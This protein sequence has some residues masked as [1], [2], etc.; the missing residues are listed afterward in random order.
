MGEL[1]HGRRERGV[2]RPA[3]R[4]RGPQTAV[5]AGR[6]PEGD[7]WE[8]TVIEFVEMAPL[9]GRSDAGFADAVSDDGLVRRRKTDPN[10][11]F[12]RRVGFRASE[13]QILVAV[14]EQPLAPRAN[15]TMG[16][17]GPYGPATTTTYRPHGPVGR[18]LGKVAIDLHVRAEASAGA[19]ATTG[20]TEKPS[21][22][23]ERALSQLAFLPEPVR[24]SVMGR[25]PAPEHFIAEAVRLNRGSIT[26]THRVSALRL[27][28]REA[29]V[30]VGSL[31]HGATHWQVEQRTY[32]FAEQPALDAPA[33]R[34]QLGR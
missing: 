25:A 34:P 9:L 19:A 30:V 5:G 4:G 20:A 29:I 16:V 22:A 13:D 10:A 24:R 32:A 26:P 14:Q 21:R 11:Y 17:T 31:L 1:I 2:N 8:G 33:S 18:R 15:G 27:D 3:P 28:G 23:H 6:A 12:R 7:R